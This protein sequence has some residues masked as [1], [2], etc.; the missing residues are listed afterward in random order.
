MYK[1]AD[2]TWKNKPLFLSE[3]H[4]E[5]FINRLKEYVSEKKLN[6]ILVIYHGGEPL[7]FGADKIIRLSEKIRGEIAL[8]NCVVDFGIQTNGTL[9]TEA[10]LQ[11]FEQQNISVSLSIDG[12]QEIHDHFRIDHQGKPSFN[13]VYQ[14]LLMLKKFPRVFSGC[15]AVINP[16][17][18]PR[19]LFE[20]FAENEVKEFNILLPDANYVA[21]PVGRKENPDLYKDWLIKAFDCWFDQFQEVKCKFF[22]S[23]LMSFLGHQGQSDAFGLGDIS[24]VTIETDGTYHDLDVLK[25]TEEYSSCLGLDLENHS[26]LDVEKSEK[27][28]AHRHLLTKEGLSDQCLSCPHIDVCGGDCLIAIIRM[29]INTQLSIAM[30]CIP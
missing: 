25:I 6:R 27:I 26:F 2:Q 8:C 4:Q 18:E 23:I 12:P 29:D 5:L 22:E 17:F 13:K 11:K 28:E 3:H 9:L 24:M 14:A 7:L 1:H 21:L 20:F 19:K 30:K 16:N 15:I 10:T